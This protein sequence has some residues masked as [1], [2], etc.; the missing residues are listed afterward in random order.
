MNNETKRPEE[1]TLKELEAAADRGDPGAIEL[2]Q[3]LADRPEVRLATEAIIEQ[4]RKLHESVQP[5]T[6]AFAKT[7]Q[8]LYTNHKEA[9]DA[10]KDLKAISSFSRTLAKEDLDNMLGIKEATLA[11]KQLQAAKQLEIAEASIEDIEKAYFNVI[12]CLSVGDAVALYEHKNPGIKRTYRTRAKAAEEGAI[13]K[14]PKT[15]AIPTNPDYQYSV[16]FYQSGGAYLQPLRST[17]GLKFKNG[18]MYFDGAYMKE[19]SEVELQNMKTKEGIDD[20]DL[21]ILRT[22]YSIILTQFEESNYKVLRDV[23]TMSV[24][25]LAEFMGLQ[26]NLNQK[27]IDRVIEK[28]QSYH[29]I[30]G[31]GH[32]TRNGKPA[33]SLYPVLNFE[34]YNYKTNTISF[35]S[36]YMNYVIRTVYNLSLRKSKDGKVK[37]KKNGKPLLK[38]SYSYLINSSIVKERNRAAVENV[39]IL[40]TLIEQAGSSLPNIY[41]STIVERNVQLEERLKNDPQHKAQLLKRVFI[42]T[43]ELMKTK[44]DLSQKYKNLRI[45]IDKDSEGILLSE[46]DPKDPAFIPTVK[47]LDDICFFFPSDG[48]K[49]EKK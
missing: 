23:L 19:V 47:N 34:G 32:G 18:K 27:D 8:N 33:Q 35:S 25:A 21:P 16:S 39:V 11:W 29:N 26:S 41:A 20:I 4:A 17:D 1:M 10:L 36:P 42:K 43:W 38:P 6:V 22:F 31:I 3:S 40:V 5:A 49:Q 37:Y 14:A 28:T 9:C 44:T 45:S 7:M 12:G 2:L 30:V 15:L 46:L 24:P 48:K 13:I